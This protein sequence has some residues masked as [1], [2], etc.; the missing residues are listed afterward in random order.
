LPTS[1]NPLL[2]F[3]PQGGSKEEPEDQVV[4]YVPRLIIWLLKGF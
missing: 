1:E 4:I 3:Y 2:R